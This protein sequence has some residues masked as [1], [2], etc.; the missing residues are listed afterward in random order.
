[1][2]CGLVSP[3]SIGLINRE[4]VIQLL[5]KSKLMFKVSKLIAFVGS[6]CC[7][8]CS[9]VP[10]II[11]STPALYWIEFL[12]ALLCAAYGYHS[13]NINFSQMT[14]FYIICLYLKL[15]LRNAN[16]S[17]R[18]SFEVKYKMTNYK[19][20][21][22]LKSMDSII[23]EINIHNNDFWSKYL[24]IVLMLVIITFDIL[25]F[26]S[27][28][29][30]MSLFFKILLFYAS[31]ILFLLLIILINTASSVSFEANKSYKLLNKL[32]ITI[33]KKKQIWIRM[34]IKV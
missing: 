29:G 5:N 16:N 26:E 21:N 33:G 19:M 10:L 28:F 12:W 4:D 2:I 23:S 31:N 18:K 20:K 8:C 13:F 15:K 14:Y 3:K 30:K 32:F 17:I 6:F 34:R 27:L 11:N 9:G 1:M 7:F 25:L 22:I 24:I